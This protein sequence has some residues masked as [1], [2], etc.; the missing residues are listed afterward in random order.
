MPTPTHPTEGILMKTVIGLIAV[1]ALLASCSSRAQISPSAAAPGTLYGGEV[2]TWDE[3]ENTVTLYNYGQQFRVRVSP[4]QLRTLR[5]HQYALVRGELA[6]PAPIPHVMLPGQSMT[7]VAR[8]TAEKIELTGAVTTVD[9]NGRVSIDSPKGPV[10]LW[11]A[12]GAD[13]R[14]PAG[15]QTRMIVTLQPVDMV[16]G[17]GAQPSASPAAD[18]MATSPSTNTAEDYSVVVGRIIG[19]N[20]NGAV[21]I[22]SPSGPIQVFVASPDKYQVSQYVQ[23]RTS[24]QPVK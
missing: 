18:T 20:P 3:R 13:Q 23:V 6:P 1:V 16:P 7:P 19:V 17:S 12:S 4:E 14:F 10:H 15:S 11:V 22:E 8:G 2:W 21:I 24:L 5:L 9:P